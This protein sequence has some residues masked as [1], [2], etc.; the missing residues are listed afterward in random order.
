MNALLPKLL[1]YSC[2]AFA[3]MR[4]FRFLFSPSSLSVT[5]RKGTFMSSE[6][7]GFV[8]VL[9][10]RAPSM[11]SSAHT[12]STRHLAHPI[13]AT[14]SSEQIELSFVTDHCFLL[15]E[16]LSFHIRST[17]M[18]SPDRFSM[19]A[20]SKKRTLPSASKVTSGSEPCSHTRRPTYSMLSRLLSP[21][22]SMP[23]LPCKKP[24][25]WQ[26]PPW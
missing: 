19:N 1:K 12:P 16:S 2:K 17:E 11:T 8:S 15:S 22:F 5:S 10:A 9:L 4:T 6:W 23:V 18:C 14:P 26:F 25:P 20:F 21:L 3:T 7:R 13:E 24:T